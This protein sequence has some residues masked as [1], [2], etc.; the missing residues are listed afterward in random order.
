MRAHRIARKHAYLSI[1][2]GR[3]KKAIKDIID[4]ALVLYDKQV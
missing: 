1:T 4:E 3:K 2:K